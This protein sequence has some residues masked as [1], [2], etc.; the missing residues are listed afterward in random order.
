MESKGGQAIEGR[1]LKV[2]RDDEKI[3]RSFSLCCA[4][5]RLAHVR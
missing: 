1:H 3:A 4:G 5:S 2:D